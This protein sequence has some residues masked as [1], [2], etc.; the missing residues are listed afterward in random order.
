M[1]GHLPS[2]GKGRGKRLRLNQVWLCGVEAIQCRGVL[3]DS[4]NLQ[5]SAHKAGDVVK[6]VGISVSKR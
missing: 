1:P 2:G 6:A 3:C 4:F 5:E